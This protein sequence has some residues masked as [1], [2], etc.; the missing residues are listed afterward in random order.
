MDLV[1]A[2]FAKW[3]ARLSQLEA[4]KMKSPSTQVPFSTQTSSAP[5]SPNIQYLHLPLMPLLQLLKERIQ[6]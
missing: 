4:S 5:P 1:N 3:D 6:M 2:H